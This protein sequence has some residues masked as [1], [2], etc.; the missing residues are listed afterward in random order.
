MP[1]AALDFTL[2]L[3]AE[4]MRNLTLTQKTIDSE[5]EVVK[6]ELRV[7]LEN[8]PVT[9]AL[10]KVMHL[11]YTTHPYMQFPIGEKKMLDTV[12]IADCRKFYDAYYQ[13]NNATM[14]V[15][16]DTDEATVK[17][18]VQEHFGKIPRGPEPARPAKSIARKFMFS[19]S[20]C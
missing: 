11:A 17:R 5:R 15:V 13:P 7:R 14:I 19:M 8:N 2:K 3:E 16:G 20:T 12:T 18:L 4:R 10:D 1:P 9:K 6:E